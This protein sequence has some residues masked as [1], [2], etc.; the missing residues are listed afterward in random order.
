MM[1]VPL[2]VISG[3]S[4][5]NTLLSLISPVALFKSLAVTR[6][7]AENVASLDLHSTML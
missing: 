1:N 6:K 5:I 7:A 4:P 3:K 2:G